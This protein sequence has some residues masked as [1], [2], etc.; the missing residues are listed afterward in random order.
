MDLKECQKLISIFGTFIL[1]FNPLDS[2]L[3]G[4]LTP[5][6]DIVFSCIFKKVQFNPRWH[7]YQLRGKDIVKT[8]LIEQ[9]FL[10][11]SSSPYYFFLIFPHGN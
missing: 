11:I 8:S 5:T 1:L 9:E 10:I 4:T 7:F 6:C 2:C 3:D